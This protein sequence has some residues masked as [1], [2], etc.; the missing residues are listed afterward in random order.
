MMCARS[1]AATC[2]SS[3]SVRSW[4]S[5]GRSMRSRMRAMNKD[6]LRGAGEDE[7]RDLTQLPVLGAVG[8]ALQR[9]DGTGV[10]LAR[11]RACAL[12]AELRDVGVLAQALVGA[13]GLAQV[14]VGPGHVEDVVHDLEEHTQFC[15]E[16]PPI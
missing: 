10:G 7:V 12:E 4:R 9:A 6:R 3:S 8:G 14:G 15:G 13:V 11:E 2:S 16:H 5:C 1:S